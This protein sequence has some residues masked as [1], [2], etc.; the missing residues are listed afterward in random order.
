MDEY[1]KQTLRLI[2]QKRMETKTEL[3]IYR[4]KEETDRKKSYKKKLTDVL[5]G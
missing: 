4:F 1:V 5:T 2:L 3:E